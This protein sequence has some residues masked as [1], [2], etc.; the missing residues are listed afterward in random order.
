MV[1][2]INMAVVLHWHAVEDEYV[3]FDETSGQTHQLDPIRAF[4]L[5]ALQEKYL[6]TQAIFEE[7]CL[8]L[9]PDDT[10]E[11]QALTQEILNEFVSHGLAEVQSL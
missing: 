6:S 7:L 1:Y 8:S 4:I 9:K 5:N 11:L 2:Q 3:V 10:S